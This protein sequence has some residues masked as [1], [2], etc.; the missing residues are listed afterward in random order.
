MKMTRRTSYASSNVSCKIF[1]VTLK[2]QIIFDCKTVV[3]F[4]PE[5]KIEKLV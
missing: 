1:T 4:V 2:V 5:M 3:D